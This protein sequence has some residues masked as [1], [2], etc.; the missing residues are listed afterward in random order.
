MTRGSPWQV[1]LALAWMVIVAACTNDSRRCPP[2]ADP[3]NPVDATLMAFLSR[4]RAAHHL[5]DLQED[6]EPGRA[7]ETLS[8]LVDG[9]L[10]QLSGSTPSEVREVLADT[11]ARVAELLSRDKLFEAALRRVTTALELVPEVG[12]F[13]GHLF[14]TR[15]LVEQRLAKELD[16]QSEPKL[17][18]SARVRALQA[19]ETAM[20][21]QAE[22]IRS[23][24]ASGSSVRPGPVNVGSAN[25]S[26]SASTNRAEGR[27]P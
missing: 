15:G 16:A 27:D 20:Q 18:E 2:T 4:A 14:E 24:P 12:Y 23:T 19:F 11:Q 5:A 21:I 7:V 10:P 17:A 8:A 25:P 9:P 6:T 1:G 22:V 13:R 3:G 26:A